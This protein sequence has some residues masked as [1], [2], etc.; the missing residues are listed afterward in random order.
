MK[1]KPFTKDQVKKLKRY[2]KQMRHVQN[3]FDFAIQLLEK[4]MQR[5]LKIKDLEFF[6]VDGEIVGIGNV[7]RTMELIASY[8]LEEK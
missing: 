6:I 8:K 4:N 2:W 7:A 3:D 5:N 1:K